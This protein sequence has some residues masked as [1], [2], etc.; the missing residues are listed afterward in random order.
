MIDYK[1]MQLVYDLVEKYELSSGNHAYVTMKFGGHPKSCEFK[2]KLELDL[3]DQDIYIFETIDELIDFLN[4]LGCRYKQKSRFNVGQTGCFLDWHQEIHSFEIKEFE[5]SDEH[6]EL[7]YFGKTGY[8]P[9]S[10]LYASKKELIE[11]QIQKWHQML[12]EE[13]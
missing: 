7:I 8:V 9:E 12:R 4:R 6:D 5:F 1:Q 10:E 13:K 11:A 3:N 2:L